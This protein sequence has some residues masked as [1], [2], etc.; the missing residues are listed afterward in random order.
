M[1]NYSAGCL[2]VYKMDERPK[3]KPKTDKFQTGSKKNI[4]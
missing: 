1:Q 3:S 4:F 2:F